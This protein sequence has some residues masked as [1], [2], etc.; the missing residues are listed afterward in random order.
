[1]GETPYFLT[2]EEAR[3]IVKQYPLSL[4]NENLTLDDAHGRIL[5][6][7]LAS[8]VDDPAFNNSAMDGFAMRF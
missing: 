2:L 3:H 4:G 1:M 5:A 6:I 8:K 7:D